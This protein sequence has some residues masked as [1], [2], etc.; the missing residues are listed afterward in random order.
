M[1]KVF[2]Q[3]GKALCYFLVYF[4]IQIIFSFVL[5]IYHSVMV[6]IEMAGKMGQMDA[7]A[8]MNGMP[9]SGGMMTPEMVEEVNA[10]VYERVMDSA[11][12]LV[13]LSGICTILVL[14]LFFVIR[15]KKF[16]V[17]AEIIPFAK[18]QWIPVIGMGLGI[19]LFC[20]G[21]LSLLPIPEEILES[22]AQSSSGLFEQPIWIAILSNIIAAPV[23]EEVVFRGLMNTRL[24]KA[25][26]NVVAVLI[27][28]IVFG[29]M[30]GHILWA[31]YAGLMGILFAITAI[32]CKSTLASIIVHMIVNTMGTVLA[33]SGWIPTTMAYAV[34]CG[35][36]AIFLVAVLV[37]LYKK[38]E[39][40]AA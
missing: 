21:I 15:K 36:G 40:V 13:I 7:I 2:A 30:H 1:K 19:G 26:P 17:E 31:I 25:M 4:G 33:Y 9:S 10:L 24:R 3:L 37:M 18:K 28:S 34:M 11:S 39:V 29:I 8:D 35:V 38:Q 20:N 22:Y 16:T 6:G 32:R 12:I 27:T 5:T 23:V 14:W